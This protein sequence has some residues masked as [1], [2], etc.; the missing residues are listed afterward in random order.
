LQVINDCKSHENRVKEFT[1]KELSEKIAHADKERQ[2]RF[3][4]IDTYVKSVNQLTRA[5]YGI[6]LPVEILR[7]ML[8]RKFGN[9][10]LVMEAI[11]TNVPY[12]WDGCY[13]CVRLDRG[14]NYDP[15]KQMT[16]VSK[17]FEWIL[18]EVSKTKNIL[19]ISSP[20]LSKDII[21][22]YIEPL[23]KKD[24]MVKIVTRKDLN[25]EEQ[26]ESLNYLS[27]LMKNYKNIKVRYLDSLHAK[28]SVTGSLRRFAIL[29][30]V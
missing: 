30:F 18:E 22:K 6:D 24:V 11:I 10:P 9:D 4:E 3:N 28:I 14:C 12:C 8:V 5:E 13:N 1:S 26:M 20:W 27:K 7:N 2:K 17:R 19:R 23:L 21:Q 29:V 25:N 15:F 16:R